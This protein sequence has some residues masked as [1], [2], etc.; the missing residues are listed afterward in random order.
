MSGSGAAA[1]PCASGRVN[2]ITDVATTSAA[3]NDGQAL[4]GIHTRLARRGLL[5]TEHLV[6][7]GYTSLVHLERGGCEHQVTVSGP[8]PGNPT[9]QHRRGEGFNRDDFPIDF[10]R[11]QVTGPP[12]EV[13]AGWHGPYPSST[14]TAAPLIVARFTQSQCRLCPA[15]PCCPQSRPHPNRP[16]GPPATRSAPES[17]APA[18]DL[19]AGRQVP[20]EG[21]EVRRCRSVHGGRQEGTPKGPAP[22][23]LEGVAPW[24]G[25]HHGDPHTVRVRPSAAGARPG[26]RRQERLVEHLVRPEHPGRGRPVRRAPRHAGRVISSR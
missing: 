25:R 10:D 23:P 15:A 7:G 14:P 22:S 18:G 1:Q 19:A 21:A 16:T 13:S 8:L 3:T 20:G 11:R 5:P 17:R 2:V 26:C 12:C 6:D 24:L 9:R 4:P